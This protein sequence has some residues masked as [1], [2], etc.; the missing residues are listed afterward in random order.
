VKPY[1]VVGTIHAGCRLVLTVEHASN[2]VPLPLVGSA[3]DEQWLATHWGW[4]PGAAAVA[5]E[6]SANLGAVAVLAGFSR[7]VVDANRPPDHPDL[8]RTAVEGYPLSFN[9]DLSEAERTR[10]VN[11]LHVPYHDAIDRHLAEVRAVSERVLLVSVH[12]FTPVFDTVSRPME[13]GV[14]FDDHEDLAEQWACA[15]EDEGYI[16]ARNEPYSG[17]VGLIYAAQRHGRNHGIDHLE[18]EMRQDLVDTPAGAHKVAAAIGRAL[19]KL[20]HIADEPGDSISYSERI[21]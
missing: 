8:I 12:S 7:L 11:A 15:L 16:T 20:P 1:R 13:L 9:R 18:L 21:V 5:T 6:L 10:R 19:R 17:R 3:A 4:D 2:A 14:L